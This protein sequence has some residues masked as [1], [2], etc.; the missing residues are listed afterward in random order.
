MPRAAPRPCTHPGCGALVHDGSGRCAR[1][2][3][4]AWTKRADMPRR[5]TGRRLQR[6]R[7][8]LFD[9]QPLCVI[10]QARGIIRMATQRD[11]IVPVAEGGPD[12]RENTQALCAECNAVKGQAEAARGRAR[13]GGGG[14]KV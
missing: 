13:A 3:R 9:E 6:E 12:A 11:H 10:C 2:P 1:H 8:R 7:K 5:I 4:P 14:K